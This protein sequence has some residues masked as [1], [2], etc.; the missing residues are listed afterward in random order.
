MLRE[1]LRDGDGRRLSRGRIGRNL[2]AYSAVIKEIGRLPRLAALL[3]EA[4]ADGAGG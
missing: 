1:S 4:G 2:G 3:A